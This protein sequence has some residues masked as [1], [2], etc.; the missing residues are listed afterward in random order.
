MFSAKLIRT[1]KFSSLI[2]WFIR[3]SSFCTDNLESIEEDSW[4]IACIRDKRTYEDGSDASFVK[5]HKTSD[6]I[7]DFGSF[8]TIKYNFVNAIDRT[9]DSESFNND[10]I[11]C[12]IG[13]IEFKGINN[14]FISSNK[15]YLTLQLLSSEKFLR[16]SN[17][18]DGFT[19]S[20]VM[21]LIVICLTLSFSSEIKFLNSCTSLLL[22]TTV[23]TSPMLAAAAF[24]AFK[25]SSSPSFTN[26]STSSSCLKGSIISKTT[27]N[28]EQEAILE[29]PQVLVAKDFIKGM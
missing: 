23:N 26:R 1:S 18:S 22:G 2:S 13:K 9:S 29:F 14:S 6:S 7:T 27:G 16:I 25:N 24:L 12:F 15:A 21:F 8:C 10:R 5:I 3:G 4:Q 28:K 20:F 17:V 19:I 11:S